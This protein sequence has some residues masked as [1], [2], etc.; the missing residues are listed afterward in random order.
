[1]KRIKNFLLVFLAL[2][3]CVSICACSKADNSISKEIKYSNL[4]NEQEI[5][6][7]SDLL[8]NCGVS[9][10]NTN[11]VM[12][13]VKNY[14]ETIGY[15]LL[16]DEGTIDLSTPIPQYDDLKIDEMWLKKNETFI[17]YNCRLTAFE[18]MKDFI[19]IE[20]TSKS[21]ASSLFMD[22]D[23]INNSSDN[24]LISDDLSKFEALY[25]TINTSSSTDVNEQYNMQKK[26][27]DSIGVKFNNLDKIS[28]ISVYIHNH[29]SDEENELII[30]HTGV[31]VNTEAGYIFFEKLSFQLPYQMIRFNNKEELKKYLMNA[32]D[33][34]TTGESAKPFIL[35][36][37]SLL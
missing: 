30:G 21:N 23:A 15:N 3:M 14:N 7:L 33:T 11:K 19:T 18:L 22:E 6:E 12:A 34:D 1:M 24:Y 35:E 36:N 26:Y 25:S 27:W 13:S 28:L 20:D 5:D 29:F 2:T 37:N 4:V 10:S 9:E 16:K 8:I 32:Y 31:L 17:G